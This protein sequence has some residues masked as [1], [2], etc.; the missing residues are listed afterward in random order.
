MNFEFEILREKPKFEIILNKASFEILNYQNKNDN[1]I[2]LFEHI[3]S[4]NIERKRINWL[5]TIFAFITDIFTSSATGEIYKERDKLIIDY[6]NKRHEV[7]LTN[8]DI[9]KAEKVVEKIT[10]KVKSLQL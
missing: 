4:I 3:N 1:K 7:F 6:G 9:N 2:Y 10:I 8:C 5:V